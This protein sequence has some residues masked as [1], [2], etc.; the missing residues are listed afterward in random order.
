M[1]G[2]RDTLQGCGA[3]LAIVGLPLAVMIWAASV[4]GPSRTYEVPLQYERGYE[5]GY[6]DGQGA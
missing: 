1:K 2:L 5:H 4:C 6:R 3:A